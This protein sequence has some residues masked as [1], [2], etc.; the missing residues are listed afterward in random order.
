MD[1]RCV[2]RPYGARRGHHPGAGHA[3]DA[4]GTC[5]QRSRG[6]QLQPLHRYGWQRQR[7]LCLVRRPVRCGC[8]LLLQPVRQQPHR[9]R[10]QPPDGRYAGQSA[11]VV[12][13]VARSRQQR[14]HLSRAHFRSGR[15]RDIFDLG[16]H[17]V[18]LAVG[19]QSRRDTGDLAVDSALK[20][21]NLD[22]AYGADD[23]NGEIT[24][25]A[26]FAELHIPIGDN[27][28]VNIAGRYE[29][30][31][32][33]GEDTTDPKIT[34]LYR[35]FD[36]LS[37]RA[38]WGSSF[39][40]A[41]MQ[42]LFGSLTTVAN[43]TDVVTG[44]AF[45]PSITQGNDQ[46]V[47]ETAD[48]YNLGFSWAP[49]DGILDGFQIDLDYYNVAYK[50]VISRESTNVIIAEDNAM[51]A[52]AV[53]A[54]TYANVTEAALAGA[55]NTRQMIRS[56]EG[57]LVRILPDFVNAAEADVD[58]VDISTS[59]T[60]E[61]GFGLWRVGVQGAWAKTYDVT[62]RGTETDAIGQYNQNNVVARP[63]PEFKWNGTLA[64]S[65]DKHRAF[66]LVQYIDDV[67]YGR[68]GGTEAFF[69]ET[70]RIALGDGAASNIFTKDIESM[71]TVDVQYTY[72][73]GEMAML[74]DSAI[75]VGA[76]NLTDE[77]P[78]WVPVVNSFAPAL[79]DP[80]GRVWFLR[81]SAS[82]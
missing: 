58:G 21:N 8:L 45:L 41:S 10:R 60:F 59:Y 25:T 13:L 1:G 12:R 54:G 17:A 27:L 47:P 52:A 63:L 30:F 36:S 34:L 66:M 70:V 5:D 74:S 24:T 16:D 72:S 19:A 11:G 78:P 48:T 44:T 51:L 40:V 61:T 46:L 35:P 76:K 3:I 82:M 29:E 68:L 39:R 18:G 42:Q 33:I 69:R 50:D 56:A 77:E 22:F 26:F 38:S 64:W 49:T 20:S 71:T 57:R 2:L 28:E 14:C 65:M 32:E 4:Y 80:R 81:V 62:Y 53:A 79:H 73:F 15:R 43:Q 23:W 67:N 6:S 31:D 37:L 9:P 7:S 75:S 55:G